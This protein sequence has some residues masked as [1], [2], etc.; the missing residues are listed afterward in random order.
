VAGSGEKTEKATPQRLREARKRGEIASSPELAM[1]LV[2]LVSLFALQAQGGHIVDGLLA[3]L[4]QDLATAGHA[5]SLTN[6]AIVAHLRDDVAG[7][8]LLLAPLVAVVLVAALVVGVLNTRGLVSFKGITPSLGK[9]NPLQGAKRLFSK[10]GLLLLAKAL[11]KLALAVALVSAASSTW[12]SLLAQLPFMTTGAACLALWQSALQVGIQI[13]AVY[14]VIGAA[15]FGYRYYSWNKRLR[16]TKEEVKQEFKQSEGNPQVR[17]RM[18]QAGR[19]RLRSLMSGTGIRRVPEADVIITN[20]THFA[21]AISY[22]AGKMR[23]PKVIAKG[24][25]LAAQRIKEA[26]RKHKIP[27]VENKPLAQ[28][29]FKSVDVNKEI[30]ADLYQAVAQVLAFVYRMKNPTPAQ[31][32]PPRRRSPMPAGRQPR[33]AQRG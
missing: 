7:G 25:N 26:A 12:Q 3:L 17:A 30:P 16:M 27:I 18:R 8:L 9:L 5:G 13:A 29:L 10:E 19:K 32:A 1:A 2:A 20:P 31:P 24:Q 28:A 6:T 21:V 14:A 11:V 33:P 15:D 22:K 23:A 4:S